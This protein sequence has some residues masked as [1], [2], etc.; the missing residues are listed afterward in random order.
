[1]SCL[2]KLY[3]S[4]IKPYSAYWRKG[5]TPLQEQTRINVLN[6]SSQFRFHFIQLYDWTVPINYSPG[7]YSVPVEW[8]LTLNHDSLMYGALPAG[9]VVRVFFLYGRPFRLITVEREIRAGSGPIDFVF[10]PIGNWSYIYCYS[11]A[12]TIND[13]GVCI[14]FGQ[15]RFTTYLGVYDGI[16]WTA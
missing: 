5:Y 12:F 9:F 6:W 16:P 13:Y 14:P 3:L 7:F 2:S 10:S 11:F 15:V 1:M 8:K 4:Y